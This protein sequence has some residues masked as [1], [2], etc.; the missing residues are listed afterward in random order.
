[1]ILVCGN[2]KGI[3]GSV[4]HIEDNSPHLDHFGL[5]E[6]EVFVNKGL[7]TSNFFSSSQIKYSKT[8]KTLKIS[9]NAVNQK[10]R[11]IPTHRIRAMA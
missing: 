6:I 3:T 10:F 11:P 8:L 5:C 2:G 1:M 7:K 4:L 9:T